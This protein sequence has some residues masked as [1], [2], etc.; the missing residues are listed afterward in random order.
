LAEA[1]IIA[2]DYQPSIHYISAL[3]SLLRR[4]SGTAIGIAHMSRYLFDRGAARIETVGFISRI[5]RL[6]A[7]HTD[8]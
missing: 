5:G 6:L 7:A 2:F 1:A 3:R 8:A 4:A